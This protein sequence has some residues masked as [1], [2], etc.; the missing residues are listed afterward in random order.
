MLKLFLGLVSISLLVGC[1][2]L[3]TQVGYTYHELKSDEEIVYS[4]VYSGTKFNW[5]FQDTSRGGN[6]LG[7]FLLPDLV[8]SVAA[9]TVLLPLTLAH[10]G[11]RK[12]TECREEFPHN[13]K[14]KMTPGG[15]F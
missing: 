4:R 2:T 11:L 6:V 8:A 13:K 14:F 10:D 1:S 5:Q 15:A 3:V 7:F 9:D 12:P